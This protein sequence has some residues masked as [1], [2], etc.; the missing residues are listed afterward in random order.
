[1]IDAMN[2]NAK[3]YSDFLYGKIIDGSYKIVQPPSDT[4][5]ALVRRYKL[6]MG[7]GKT[8]LDFS[9]G[10]GR[11]TEYLVRTGY[12]TTATEVTQEAIEAAR[13]RFTQ[14]EVDVDLR[15]MTLE[16][17]DGRIDLPDAQFDL[18]VAW[19][20]LH[21]LASKKMFLAVVSEF[22]RVLKPGG[23]LIFSVPSNVHGIKTSGIEVGESQYE[24]V[25]NKRAGAI[26]YA[27]N[28]PTITKMIGELG[29]ALQGVMGETFFDDNDF[30]EEHPF[31][32]WCFCAK[33][34]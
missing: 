15:E 13:I 28:K 30:V 18:V 11:N 1:M 9:C 3:M 4:L 21:W 5:A 10:E 2:H 32:M 14:N 7:S 23:T 22:Y 33:K 25:N 8:A 27:P 34:Q 31:A 26:M 16:G 17:W 19:E 12:K 24:I 6:D 29:F 20:V